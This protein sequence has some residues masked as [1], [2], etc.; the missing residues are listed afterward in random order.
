[1]LI[2]TVAAKR[3]ELDRHIS[4]TTKEQR[5]TTRQA[6]ILAKIYSFVK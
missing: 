3:T 4:T 2:E 1:M 6:Y 5:K